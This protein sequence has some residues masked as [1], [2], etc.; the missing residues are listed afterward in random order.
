M[1]R[2][3][4]EVTGIGDPGRYAKAEATLRKM[5]GQAR[6]IRLLEQSLAVK[7]RRVWLISALCLAG[8]FWGLMNV[9]SV[10]FKLGLTSLS[11]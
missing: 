11:F 8:M 4:I 2:P 1:S 5:Q 6:E 9:L 10:H 3:S 7:P